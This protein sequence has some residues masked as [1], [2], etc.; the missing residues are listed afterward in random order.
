[1]TQRDGICA[2]PGCLQPVF[3]K[4]LCQGH[5]KRTQRNRSIDAPLGTLAWED[6]HEA[7][8]NYQDSDSDDTHRANLDALIQKARG[9]ARAGYPIPST[10]RRR[11]T[12]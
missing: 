7:I 4:G 8:L 3:R 5:L 1:M 10:L 9:W 12:A 11:L 6:F 2:A